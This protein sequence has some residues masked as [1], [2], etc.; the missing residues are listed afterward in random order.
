MIEPTQKMSAVVA[1]MCMLR[2]MCGKTC[3]DE[4]RNERTSE[5]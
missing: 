5:Y 2:V 1:E 3:K 4:I